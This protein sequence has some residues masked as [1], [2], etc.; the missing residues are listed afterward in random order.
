MNT[1]E[2]YM[3]MALELA[4]NGVARTSPN[5]RV[6]CVIVRDGEVIGRGWHRCCG[7]PHAE[8][9][10]V[11][12][13]G[14]DV[15]G[16]DVY[17]N[18]EPCCHYGKT[19][20]CAQM[21]VEHKVAK[22]IAGMTDPNP[23]VD[24]RGVSVLR[25]AGIEV[26][27][28]VLEKECR[29]IN[30]GFIMSMTHGRPWVT[31]KTASSLDGNIAL[32]DGSSK[33]ITGPE[34]RKIVQSLRAEN[35]AV[36]TGIGTVLSDDPQ[37]TVRDVSGRTPLRVV[38]DKHFM[39]RENAKI[40]EGGNILFFVGRDAEH[41]KIKRFEALGAEFEVN[42]AP[43]DGQVELILR[44]L[45]EKGVNYL[46]VEA[47]AGVVSSFLASRL[48][49]E[50]A[51]FIAPKLMGNGLHFTQYVDVPTMEDAITFKSVEYSPCGR[52]MLIKGVLSCSPDL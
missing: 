29:W 8:V 27:T 13:A 52:D 40:L 33:W 44:K 5:P 34:S 49:D 9:D 20:P 38:L 18:L 11:R 37:L 46:M 36:L 35:D 6:G 23:K 21:L 48:V 12:D 10:A 26:V 50:M 25:E 28:G 22:V 43:V 4:R 3:A 31:I 51:I 17:V 14:G 41:D 15:Q 39:T 24:C 32:K 16:A 47:G 2:K 1:D 42:D 45:C 7:G 30:R 19:P